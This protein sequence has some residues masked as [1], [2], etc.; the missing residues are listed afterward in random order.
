MHVAWSGDHVC[1]RRAAARPPAG[2]RSA[3]ASCCCPARSCSRRARRT[4]RPG[5]YAACVRR[6]AGRRSARASTATCAARPQHPR[7]AAAGRAQHLGGG[8]LRP[9]PRP[10]ACGSPTAAAAIGV[11]RF[12]LDDG[13]F[14]GRR[15]D[16]AGLG[17]WYV[18]A[19]RLAGRAR[20]RWSTTSAG[21]GMQFGLWVE[22]EMVNP[23]SDLVRAHPDWV[24]ARPG[25]LPLPGA[26][27]AGARPRPHPEVYDVP[28][29]AA[30]RAARPSTDIAYL[31]WD[32]NRDLVEAG[33]TGPAGP[34]CTRRRSPS[35]RCSTSC[36][37]RHP[38]V[39]IES[40]ASGGAR[41]DLGILAAHRP[42]LGQRLQRRAR[43][44][45]IQRW[46]GA[47]S[48]RRS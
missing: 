23:D 19:G 16:T 1:V 30:R 6:R 11:E 14:R 2:R 36:A 31:K 29:R 7:S 24:L 17:D 38:G 48:C 34:A 47:A 4:R 35:T 33:R 8:L 43:A 18:D 27:P 26:A 46:T 9:R 13:W 5:L 22:P 28:A 41:V 42:G 15:D 40:C 39:E 37:R 20:A 45:A 32:H 25:R 3:A 10:A 21:S 44:A 12:V